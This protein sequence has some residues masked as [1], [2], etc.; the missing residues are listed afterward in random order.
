VKLG[1]GPL[2]TED[3][4]EGIRRTRASMYTFT[5]SFPFFTITFIF[6]VS[7]TLESDANKCLNFIYLALFVYGLEIS[8][9]SNRYQTN[10][11]F[12]CK[13]YSIL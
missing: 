9:Y 8:I 10:V 2:S 5:S 6:P 13:S 3:L 7:T 1:S 4:R 11:T 12:L